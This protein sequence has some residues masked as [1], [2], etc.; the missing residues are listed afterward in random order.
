MP[1]FVKA[2]A[3]SIKEFPV[4]NSKLNDDATEINYID[5]YNVGIAVDT[6]NGLIVPNVKNVQNL[7]VFEIAQEI[8][9]LVISAR[10]GKIQKTDIDD[11]TISISN[12]GNLGGTWAYPIINHPEVAIVALGKIQTLPRF[13]ES[14][15]LKSRKIIQISW[16]GD[17]RVL[18]GGTIA[19]FCNLWKSYL[20]NPSTMIIHMK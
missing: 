7:T 5:N 20:E 18:D 19:R 15:E 12:I 4:L 8:N 1:F 14:G 3:L 16:S 11:G 10:Q 9:R 6:P 17:H 13:D 2:L